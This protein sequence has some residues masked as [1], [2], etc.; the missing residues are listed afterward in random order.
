M[1]ASF[2]IDLLA[3]GHDRKRFECGETAL[4]RYLRETAGQDV[5]RRV[6]ACY[7]AHLEADTRVAGFYTLSAGEVAL[8]DMP[9]EWAKRLPRYPAVPVARIGRL[10]V[11]KAFQGRKLGAALLWDAAKRTLRSEI[12]VHAVVVD[13]K[14]DRAVAFYSPFGFVRFSDTPS[15]MILP[16]ATLQNL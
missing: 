14:N 12:A 11:D 16:L 1:T 10:A 13:A 9:E 8:L 6:A 5:R 15:A 2:V 3:K 4:D 7:V